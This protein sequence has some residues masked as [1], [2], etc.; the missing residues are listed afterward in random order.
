MPD[1]DA[2]PVV[3]LAS[4]SGFLTGLTDATTPEVVRVSIAEIRAIKATADAAAP[5]SALGDAASMTVADIQSII[6]AR[7]GPVEEALDAI[8]YD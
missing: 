6:D 1:V 4:A 8:L 7:L 3:P 2:A 5:A